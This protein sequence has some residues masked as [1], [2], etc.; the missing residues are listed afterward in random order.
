M[1]SRLSKNVTTYDKIFLAVISLLLC[2]LIMF[3][4]IDQFYSFLE[5]DKIR[6]RAKELVHNFNPNSIQ[7]IFDTTNQDHAEDKYFLQSGDKIHF[8]LKKI[9]L[10]KTAS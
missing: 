3:E 10:I 7:S 9:L 6:N 8:F 2:Q 4:V 1:L 5:C